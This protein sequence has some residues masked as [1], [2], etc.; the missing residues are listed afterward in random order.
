MPLQAG[1][2]RFEVVRLT[3]PTRQSGPV[4]YDTLVQW[5][6]AGAI[7]PLYEANFQMRGSSWG[8]NFSFKC[9]IH[10]LIIYYLGHLISTDHYTLFNR[11]K[12]IIGA[13]LH[14]GL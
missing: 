3:C 6:P 14:Y 2:I 7:L 5:F 11:T 4:E 10:K 9:S 12:R 8:D 1:G 13:G